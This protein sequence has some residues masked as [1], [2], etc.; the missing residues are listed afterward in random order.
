MHRKRKPEDDWIK[1]EKSLMMIGYRDI[2]SW[3]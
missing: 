3:R 2:K 1:K